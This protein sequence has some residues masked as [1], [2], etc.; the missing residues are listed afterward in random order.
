MQVW[1]ILNLT[2]AANRCN[3]GTGKLYGIRFDDCTPGADTNGDGTVDSSDAAVITSSSSYISWITVTDA[4]TIIYGS[5][6]VTTDGSSNAVG[7]IDTVTNPFLGTTTVFGWKF[8][9]K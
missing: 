9:E 4:G 5:S 8:S 3:G 1:F 7:T 2:P 6:G